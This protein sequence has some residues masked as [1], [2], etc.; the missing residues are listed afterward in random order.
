[1]KEKINEKQM[2][3]KY[4]FLKNK[5]SFMYKSNI[6]NIIAATKTG[7]DNIRENLDDK[8]RLYPKNLPADMIIPDLLT[9]GI[10]AID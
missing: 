4:T 8:Y 10:R 7:I 1:M 9:P 6:S 3:N 2:P 5:S